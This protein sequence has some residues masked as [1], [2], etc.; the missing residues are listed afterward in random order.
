MRFELKDGGLIK[1]EMKAD[2]VLFDPKTMINR[3]KYQASDRS[4]EGTFHLLV[5]GEVALRDNVQMQDWA[6]RL[7]D[8][9]RKV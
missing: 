4:S 6:G 2:I 5:N 3:A 8:G 7:I 9:K 1:P